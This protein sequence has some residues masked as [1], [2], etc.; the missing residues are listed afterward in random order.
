VAGFLIIIVLLAAFWF[1]AVLPRRRRMQE[2]RNMQDAI[3]DGDEVITAGGLHGRVREIDEREVRL[4]I[5]EGVVVTVDRR[6]IA[7]VAAEV[8]VEVEAAQTGEGEDNG[9]SEGIESLP[10]PAPGETKEPR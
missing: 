8:E 9:P 10:A 5:A 6:A 4:E 1:V 3:S 7:A 2:H